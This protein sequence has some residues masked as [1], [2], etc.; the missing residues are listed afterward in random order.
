MRFLKKSTAASIRVGRLGLSG[1]D[2]VLATHIQLSKNGGA[3]AQ[4]NEA[5]KPSYDKD[6]WWACSLDATDTNTAGHLL[7]EVYNGTNICQMEYVVLEEAAFNA[8]QGTS[9]LTAA[10]VNAEVVD[11]VT[12][13][14]I[15]EL[16]QAKPAATPTLATAVMLM[17]MALRNEA[18]ETA[19][20]LSIK[21]DAGTT[22]TKA[23]IS[24]DGTTFTKG[25]LATGA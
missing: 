11:A 6:G 21:N 25:E 1:V 22:I 4:K 12:V 23:T 9:W 18:T 10:A 2:D 24:D 3:F 19:T 17:Y 20:L 14:T 5:Q 16:P 13:D 8:I 7:I 15:A